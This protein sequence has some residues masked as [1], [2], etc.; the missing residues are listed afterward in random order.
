MNEDYRKPLPYIHSE[1]SDYWEGARR[2]ELLAR[3]CRSCGQYHFYPRDFC[4]SCF[5][6]DVG[7]IKTSGRGRVY[8]FTVCHRPARGFE[9]EVPY[10]L[11]LIELNKGFRMMSCVVDCPL[12][13]IRTG[14]TV[15]V[16]F[17]DVTAQVSLPKFRPV[18]DERDSDCGD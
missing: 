6:P 14:M 3:H 10:N 5:S 17:D 13:E 16:T 7:W 2:H 9:K 12:D 15:E 11:A 1:T 4:P 18:R 8:S